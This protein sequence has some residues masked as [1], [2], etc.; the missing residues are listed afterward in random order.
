[1]N[2]D[3]FA[4]WLCRQGYRV[5]RT[6]S[7]YWYEAGARVLQAFPYHWLIEP[8]EKELRDLLV[9]HS[10]I[11]LRY[12]TPLS[13][14]QGKVSYHIVC[15]DP[16]YDLASLTRQARQNTRRGL[17]Y[18]QVEQ[19]PLS[20]L[21]EEGWRLRRDSLERQGR[22]GAE[23]EAGWRR[24]CAAADDLPGFEAWGA[25]HE[26]EL[27]ASFLAFTCGDCFTLPHEQ[28]ATAHLEHRPNNALFYA[29]TREAIRRPGISS[30]FFCLHS[31]DA[32]ASMDEF[33]LRM[34][35]TAK[36]VRQRVV[37]HP[38]LSPLANKMSHA[39]IR[40]ALLRSPSSTVLAKAE[41]MMRFYLEGRRPAEVQDWPECLAVHK[42]E[43]LAAV[44]EIAKA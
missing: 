32:P 27:A 20:R 11:A 44:H 36:P 39:T 19:I 26:G 10:A 15:E 17:E 30:A 8:T 21:A 40:S 12:S 2:A 37:F 42:S 3:V 5:V 41:G 6:A 35:L 16:Q 24:M 1:M 25:L 22:L 14:G 34:G 33:K 38:L 4:E 23:N 18:A 43:M 13:V 9:R 28:S 31:L 7:S 29:V